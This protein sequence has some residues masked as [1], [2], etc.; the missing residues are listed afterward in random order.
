MHNSYIKLFK[1]V[2]NADYQR[3][4]KLILDIYIYLK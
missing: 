1:Y 4:E 3:S 2:L